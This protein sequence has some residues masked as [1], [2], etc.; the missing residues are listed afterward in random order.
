MKR[1]SV[2]SRRSGQ[3]VIESVVVLILI[4]PLLLLV[5]NLFLVWLAV[6]QNDELCSEACRVACQGRADIKGDFESR[7]RAT[8]ARAAGERGDGGLITFK[9]Q[10]LTAA[11]SGEA[12]RRQIEKLSL[13]GGTAEG[14]VTVKTESAVRLLGLA[15]PVRLQ[16]CRTYPFTCK[17]FNH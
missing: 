7:A 17:I 12:L 9:L 1:S 5:A 14:T 2:S 13:S 6:V 3:A 4:A 16:S 11:P 8:L 15:E 10:S